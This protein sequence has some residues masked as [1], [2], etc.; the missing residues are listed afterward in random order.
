MHWGHSVGMRGERF[1]LTF[2]EWLEHYEQEVPK[3]PEPP[4]GVNHI[5]PYWNRIRA[6][7]GSG[8]GVSPITFEGIDAFARLTGEVVTQSDIVMLEAMDN[9]FISQVSIERE[10]QSERQRQES[11]ASK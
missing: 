10:E 11:E 5:W 1:K 6:R 8:E 4:P 3:C 2:A 7:T 9:A